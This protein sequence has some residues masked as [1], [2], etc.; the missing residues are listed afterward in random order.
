M[1]DNGT[2][3]LKI[4]RIGCAPGIHIFSNMCFLFKI[5]LGSLREKSNV[6]Y[7]LYSIEF[8]CRPLLRQWPKITTFKASEFVQ[9]LRIS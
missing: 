6:Q 4:P 3:I 5:F 8:T 7:F 2:P 1:I 9:N